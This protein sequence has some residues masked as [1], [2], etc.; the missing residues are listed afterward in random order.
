MEA[1]VPE[2]EAH[3]SLHLWIVTARLQPRLMYLKHSTAHWKKRPAMPQELFTYFPTC[4]L[5]PAPKTGAIGQEA[6][7]MAYDEFRMRIV[8]FDQYLSP[9][10]PSYIEIMPDRD[11][12]FSE[13]DYITLHIPETPETTELLDRRTL[14]LM[15]PYVFLINCSRRTLVNEAMEMAATRA[16]DAVLSGGKSEF[17]ANDSGGTD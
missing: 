7:V 10:L 2:V 15:K 14:S 1:Y 17:S 12:V 8:G 6:S 3:R 5:M 9:K 11:T 4:Y 13:M 16:V